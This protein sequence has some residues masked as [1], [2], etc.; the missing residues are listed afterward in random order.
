MT[1]PPTH[2][3]L[4]ADVFVFRGAEFLTLE[5]GPG[6][7]EGVYYLPG[8]AVDLGEDPLDAAVRET[9][10][11][12]GLEVRD[13]RLLRVWTYATPEGWDTVHATF[14]AWSDG[15]DVA[16]SAEHTAFHWTSPDAYLHQWCST[17]LEAAFPVHAEW[18]QQVRANIGLARAVVDPTG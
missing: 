15:G 5:R 16:L 14:V 2:A 7:G 3:G 6:R 13:V 11:E 12:S 1:T 17:E 8:G 4:T 18:I 10:E 9:Q